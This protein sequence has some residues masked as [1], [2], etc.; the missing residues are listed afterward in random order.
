[1]ILACFLI[2]ASLQLFSLE[3][4]EE[5]V[6]AGARGMSFRFRDVAFSGEIAKAMFIREVAL[7]SFASSVTFQLPDEATAKHFRDALGAAAAK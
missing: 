7:S 6:L 3:K 2:I 5:L 1:L 4:S